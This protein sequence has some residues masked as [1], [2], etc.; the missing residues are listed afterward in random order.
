M[1]RRVRKLSA[2]LALSIAL[3]LIAT[4]SGAT[5]DLS[6]L[7]RPVARG[8]LA[9]DSVYF[10][11]T[12]RFANG[13]TSNDGGG[14]TGGRLGGG[15]DST[16]IGYYHGGD[17]KGLTN[18]LQYIRDLGFNS[19]WITP[20]VKNQFVQQGS[21]AYHGYWALDFTT[22]DPHLGTEQDFKDFVAA[23]HKLGMKV[24]VD[25]VVNHTADVVKY[26][27]GATTYRE[28]ADFPYKTC[29][30]KVFD[31]AK[32][33]GLASFPKL[34]VDKSFAYVPRTSTYDKNIKKPVFLNDLTNYH[35]RGD[36]IWSGTSVTQGDFVGLDDIF[37]EKPA[38]VKGMTDLWSSWITRF[39]IDGYRIDT[40]KH[41]NPE[42]WRAF[43]PKIIATAKAAGKENFPIFGE[44]ADSDI[45][46]L[47]SFVTEQN[48][49]GVLD[50][51]FQAKV[52]RFAKA[53]GG[54]SDVADLFNTDDFYTTSTTSAYSLA[55][56]LGNHD[57]GRIGHF[58]EILSGSDG[59]QI[60]LER[61]KLANALLFTLRG[62]PVLYYGDEK[63]MTGNGGDQLARQDMFATH[64]EDWKSEV[65]IGNAPIGNSSAFDVKNPLEANVAELQGL[66][67]KYPALKSGTQQIRF[68]MGS[69][70]AVSR[71][72]D[73]QELL[74]AFN[75][76][77]DPQ[78]AT[79]P[80]STKNSTW[81]TVSGGAQYSAHATSIDLKLAPRSWV[82][83]KAD[84]VF[85]PSTALEVILNSPKPDYR[86]PGWSAITAKVPGDDF[87]QVTF[88]A[89][90]IGKAWKM[91]GTSDHR[92]MEDNYVIAG[93]HRVF[94][95]NR[96]YK[97]GTTFELVAIATNTKGEK[98]VS[99]VVNYKVKY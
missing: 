62:G 5:E 84:K 45:P 57:M 50:F 31:P 26:T 23:S 80:V 75:S 97:S 30:R 65:R 27:I 39:D 41:V 83:L 68:G 82:I 29:T 95:H 15:D 36:S 76:S 19:I 44:V 90:Q 3:S 71:Y 43:L 38:V 13:D 56:F 33:A 53:G 74:I 4:T 35:N 21:A 8:P 67:K 14:L 79:I 72:A 1:D 77:D 24:I 9:D 7:A 64:V 11:M 63:G 42:F 17:F 73:N 99:K 49:P 51:P 66:Y 96:L 92:T 78:G 52:S 28:P 34:C 69:V 12:D 88:A 86:T 93:L 98:S 60:M 94:I 61:A 46:F 37:T 85:E 58:I 18:H 48:F 81:S 47:A 16:D 89:R 2:A 87:V 10:V 40:A 59:A 32:V 54:A 70:L 6:A 20:P 91:L 22:I 25:I 55:T